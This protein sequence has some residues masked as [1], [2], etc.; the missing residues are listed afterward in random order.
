MDYS[1]LF[2]LDPLLSSSVFRY[3]LPVW[4]FDGLLNWRSTLAELHLFRCPLIAES[5]AA[6]HAGIQKLDQLTALDSLSLIS[7][8][9]ANA[10]F[11]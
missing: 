9:W 2:I 4:L 6:A 7:C 5:V 3:P 11:R 10:V 1:N 8:E